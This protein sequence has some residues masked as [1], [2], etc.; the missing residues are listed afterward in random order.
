V[1][2]PRAEL[3]ARLSPWLGAS[4]ILSIE[5]VEGGYVNK[6]YRVEAR[7]GLF[8]LRVYSP[9][10]TPEMACAE[11]ALLARVAAHMPEVPA[12]IP[13][14]ALNT[15]CPTLVS[16]ASL[17]PFI[18]GHLPDR[19]NTAHRV[20][21]ARTLGRLH[22]VLASLDG[23]P[24]RASHPA[25]ADLNWHENRLWEWPAGRRIVVRE[26]G[27]DAAAMIE[28]G[29]AKCETE[30]A[31]LARQGWARM[32]VH[33]DYY[34]GNLILAGGRIRGVVD[35]DEFR[36]DWRAWEA[37]NALWSFCRNA[38]S[39]GFDRDAT[40]SFLAAYEESGQRLLDSERTEM[41]TLIRLTRLWEALYTVGE[42]QRGG[43]PDWAYFAANLR[44]FETL[45]AVAPI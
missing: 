38:A 29:L 37:S 10:T 16:R 4:E 36:V 13:A 8:A 6:V 24:S 9:L 33:G 44:A 11:H 15:D 2:G 40:R 18:D 41:V 42:A 1:T 43:T 28:D 3:I 20:E 22:T 45:R 35:W 19:T 34:E 25:L 23:V 27:E 26:A 12:P 32:P 31:R 30:L 14:P 5:P 7:D 39:D 21:A 17:S